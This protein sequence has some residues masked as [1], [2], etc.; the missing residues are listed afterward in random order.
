[1]YP[2]TSTQ[3]YLQAMTNPNRMRLQQY[4]NKYLHILPSNAISWTRLLLNTSS[5]QVRMVS[6]QFSLFEM[7]SLFRKGLLAPLL[8][9]QRESMNWNDAGKGCVPI[10]LYSSLLEAGLRNRRTNGKWLRMKR[11]SLPSGAVTCGSSRSI[12]ASKVY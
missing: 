10:V 8:P 11:L 12:N 4:Q 9:K 5:T 7:R 2:E 1:M 6:R 3:R